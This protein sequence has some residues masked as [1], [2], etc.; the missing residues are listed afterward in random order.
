MARCTSTTTA[1]EGLKPYAALQLSGRD[2]YIREGCVGL[3]LADDPSVPRRDRA[4]RPLLGRGE[5]ATT[6]PSCGAPSA[7]GQTC[8]VWVGVTRMPAIRPASACRRW[9]PGWACSWP[10]GPGARQLRA[11]HVARPTPGTAAARPG[12]RPSRARAPGGPRTPG[13]RGP[14]GRPGS[15]GRAGARP[16]PATHPGHLARPAAPMP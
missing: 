11:L 7:P 5:Y 9:C 6:D 10:P 12:S 13:T 1:V 2:I 8:S 3:P 4:L 16:P 15:T 14:W